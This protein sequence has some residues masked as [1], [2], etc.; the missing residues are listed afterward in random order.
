MDT[1]SAENTSENTNMEF[2]NRIDLSPVLNSV[3]KIRETASR[4]IVGQQ[5]MIDLLIVAILSEGHVLIEGVPGL[6]KTLAAKLIAKMLDIKFQRIQF[7][8]DLMPS[9]V[10]GTSVFNPKTADFELRKGPVFSNVLLVDEINRAPAKTQSALFEVMEERQV[11]IDG[12]TN[13]FEY[14]FIVLAT[15]NPIEQEGTYRLPE[16]QIDRFLFKIKLTY[17]TNEEEISILDIKNSNRSHTEMN[18]VSPIISLEDL[19]GFRDLV[20]KI[21]IEGKL[22]RYITEIVAKT[23]THRSL[24]LGAS[25]RASISL[26]QST[27]AFAAYNGRDFVTPDDIKALAFPVMRHRLILSPEKELEGINSEDVIKDIL[28]GIEVPR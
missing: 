14:P 22:I 18:D 1:F 28:D 12:T 3:S 17:P 21:H 2:E 7:T 13:K 9:D 4:V 16:A 11:T 15:Q 10:L 25:P 8:P 26:L 6:G 23:R 19:L 20:N 5:K 24:Y 27:K